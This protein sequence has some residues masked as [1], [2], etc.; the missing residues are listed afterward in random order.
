MYLRIIEVF[1]QLSLR[2]AP[3]FLD[4]GVQVWNIFSVNQIFLAQCDL[5]N[6]ALPD[7][8]YLHCEGGGD[9]AVCHLECVAGFVPSPRSMTSCQDGMW[10]IPIESL[11][12]S[13]GIVL[14][15]GG[16]VTGQCCGGVEIFGADINYN[17]PEIP[18]LSVFNENSTSPIQTEFLCL[19]YEGGK[20][21]D[22]LLM[23]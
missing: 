14:I 13:E 15:E 4:L 19:E 12:C 1:F 18:S 16:D 6:T 5:P 20:N 17:F 7:S 2:L 9:Q 3:T 23:V 10:D 11:S 21:T 8:G 22:V